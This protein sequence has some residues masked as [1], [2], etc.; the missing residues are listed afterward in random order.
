MSAHPT[1]AASAPAPP[2]DTRAA[3]DR[4]QRRALA[5][6]GVALL[7]SLVGAWLDLDQ[8]LRSWLFGW[9][10]WLGLSLG[11]LAIV[12]LHHA[13]GGSWGFAIRRL[14]EAGMRTLPLVALCFVPILVFVR[15]VYPWAAEHATEHD[16]LLAHKAPYLNVP[17]FIVR[18]VVYFALWIGLTAILTGLTGKQDRSG[19]PGWERRMRQLAGPGL[20]L[21]GLTMTFAAVDWAMSLEPHWFSTIYGVIFIVGQGLS[22]LT[23]A[24]LG[25]AWL[26]SREPFRRWISNSHFHDLGNLTF[27]FVMLWGYVSFSQ[28]LIIWSGNLAEE[29]PWY[30]NRLGQGWQVLAGLLLAFHFF[31]PFVL[32]L[33]RRAKR[34]AR[35]LALLAGALLLMR[36]VDLYWLVQP[37]FRPDGLG[38]HW[39]DVTAPVAIGGLWFAYW[40]RQLKGRPLVTLQDANLAG[41]LEIGPSAEG[42]EALS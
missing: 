32:L 7:A 3:F 22:T 19:H 5:I 10:F 26:A 37:A 21:Y 12:C 1:S 35:S 30:L 28:Y 16:A 36:F 4:G 29:T 33:S 13:T 41:S 6:G 8:F 18:S 11:S 31:V 34:S 23:F 14:L 9:L 25:A 20:A 27:A 40:I 38:L 39:L 2:S 42:A 15:R 17:F 24:T